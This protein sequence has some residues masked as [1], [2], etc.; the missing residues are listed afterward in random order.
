[1]PSVTNMVSYYVYGKCVYNI[2][3]SNR[4]SSSNVHIKITKKGYWVVSGFY[5]NE[6]SS[7]KLIGLY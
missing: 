3:R 2:F 5:I 7:F 6:D 4:S 1:M